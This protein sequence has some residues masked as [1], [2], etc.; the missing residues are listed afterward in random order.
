MYPIFILS[1]YEKMFYY[2]SSYFSVL[3]FGAF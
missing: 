1:I 3:M 2:F